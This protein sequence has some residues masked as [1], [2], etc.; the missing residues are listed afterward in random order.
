MMIKA[1][2]QSLWHHDSPHQTSSPSL[3]LKHVQ[4]SFGDLEVI[5]DVSLTI[6]RGERVAVIG[7][8]GAGKST[9]FRIIA[10][11]L[12]PNSGNVL[13][14]GAAPL[15]HICVA[16]LPQRS[17]VDW[18]FPVTVRDVVLMGRIGKLGWLKQ[19]RKKDIQIAD[20]CLAAVKMQDLV[21]RQIGEL[22]GGQQQRMFIARALAQE[23]EV[24]LMDEPLNGLDNPSQEII[25]QL[26]DNLKQNKTTVLVAMHD[27]DLATE[28]FEKVMLLNRYLVGYGQAEEVFKPENLVKAYGSHLHIIQS[29]QGYVAVSDTCCDQEN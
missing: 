3:E 1:K 4:F 12:K 21:N 13:I 27:L 22:S 25:F 17:Q 9:L 6:T 24:I 23:A 8:N 28:R 5:K 16:Y 2:V 10:G 20:D 11:I 29:D 18:H 26:L 14:F 7:P 15:S 19:P